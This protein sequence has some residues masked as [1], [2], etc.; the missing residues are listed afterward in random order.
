MIYHYK[1]YIMAQSLKYYAQPHYNKNYVNSKK[2]NKHG[3]KIEKNWW[4][5]VTLKSHYWNIIDGLKFD[6]ISMIYSKIFKK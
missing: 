6:K 3:R 2:Q 5:I 1:R 4:L